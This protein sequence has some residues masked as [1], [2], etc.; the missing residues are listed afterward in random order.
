MERHRGIQPR[1]GEAQRTF[2]GA[3]SSQFTALS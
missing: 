2:Y 3:F 1:G